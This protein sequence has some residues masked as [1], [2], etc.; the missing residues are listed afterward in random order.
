MSPG[1]V[2]VDR[3][4]TDTHRPL[5]SFGCNALLCYFQQ[6]CHR[7]VVSQRDESEFALHDYLVIHTKCMHDHDEHGL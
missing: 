1:G 6:L 7:K 2:K 3:G 4:T 5:L